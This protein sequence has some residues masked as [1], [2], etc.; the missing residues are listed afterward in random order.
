MCVWVR[1]PAQGLF[2]EIVRSD[3]ENRAALSRRLTQRAEQAAEQYSIKNYGQKNCLK[4]SI[5]KHIRW[6]Q[7]WGQKCRTQ[8]GNPQAPHTKRS[9]G[10]S[11]GPEAAQRSCRTQQQ[12]EQE[13]V[14]CITALNRARI[15]RRIQ[16]SQE[17]LRARPGQPTRRPW[18][19]LV[20]WVGRGRAG[21]FLTRC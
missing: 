6:A 7:R 15:L 2:I 9:K 20:G 21:W 5:L 1:R 18:P 10:G 12:A 17:A 4:L 14:S 19:G 11:L 13:R 3:G 16:K 8:Q